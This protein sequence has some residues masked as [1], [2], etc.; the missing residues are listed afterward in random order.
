MESWITGLIQHGYSILCL[1]VFLEAIGLPIPA[2]PAL[3]IV[4]AAGARGSLSFPL[5]YGA[6]IAAM[7]SADVLLFAMGRHAGW[8]LLGVLCR[9][10]INPESCVLRS[11]ESF[12][13]RGRTL[14]VIAK[15]L[16][17]INALSA[18]MAGTMQMRFA[19]FLRWD[20]CGAALYTGVYLA[21]GYIGGD[22][23]NAFFHGYQAAGNVLAWLIPIA[24]AVYLAVKVRVWW[25]SRGDPAVPFVLPAEA[26]RSLAGGTAVIYDVR[27][28]GYYDRHAVRIR[29]SRR[30]DPAAIEEMPVGDLA[31][32]QQVYLYCT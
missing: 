25:M 19:R 8:W 17:G 32:G 9:I 27:S 10:S 14:L 28:H 31:A 5:A 29:G 22:L 21:A 16:P 26:A 4:G 24:I 3:L 1:V 6:A 23:V 15:F 30:I 13:R 20:F 2:A 11:A 7:M 12:R 18:P